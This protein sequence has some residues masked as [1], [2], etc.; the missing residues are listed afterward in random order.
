[1]DITLY[2][3]SKKERSTKR[4]TGGTVYRGTLREPSG[5]LSPSFTIEGTAAWH[6]EF[7]YVY[8][9]DFDRYYWVDEWTFIHGCLWL[10]RT[11]VDVL[12]SWKDQIGA[13]SFYILRSSAAYNGRVTDSKYPVMAQ[14]STY[15]DNASGVYEMYNGSPVQRAN[16]WNRTLAQ[17]HYYLGVNGAN[18]T[19][20]DWYVMTPG[21]FNAMV[22]ALYDLDP[23]DM[24]SLDEGVR[25]NLAN[26]MQYIVSCYWL[27]TDV[28]GLSYDTMDIQ[29]GYYTISVT[30]VA[31]LDPVK[32]IREYYAEFPIRKH[33]QA[34]SRGAYLNQSPTSRY[35]IAFQPFGTFELDSSLMIDD[36]T[37]RA[38]WYI[39]YTTGM[40]DLEIKVT[41][42]FMV[43]T[44]A[45]LAIPIQLNQATVD[46]AGSIGG[47]FSGAMTALGGMALG[48]PAMVVGG[49][50]GGIG[51]GLSGLMPKVT[52]KGTGG[53]FVP[54][55]SVPPRI[56]SDFYLIAD[57]YNA[58]IGRP[59]CEVRTPASLGGYIQTLEGDIDI[60][61]TSSE[62]DAISGYL[63]G[64]FFYE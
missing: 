15:I 27:P 18:G 2:S 37:A 6:P 43:H 16:Y 46:Y 30:T 36:T 20:V 26:P 62:L 54:F 38:S 52:T 63:T 47:V 28:I 39:D 1:M 49:I 60:P 7:N 21:S 50:A 19:G 31:K 57:E 11:H 9:P 32:A 59:L 25:K 29:F 58:E 24:P 51:S 8:L 53:N 13:K 34:A 44:Q 10:A 55:N 33:P 17:G 5:I 12:A 56:Y 61:A 23:N 40:A 14:P 35:S 4:P 64:G 42:S 3:F 48:N 22:K 41:N 45:Q